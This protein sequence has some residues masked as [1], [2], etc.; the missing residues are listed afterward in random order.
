MLVGVIKLEIKEQIKKEMEN[1]CNNIKKLRAKHKLT[2]KGMAKIL[3][4]GVGSLTKIE[5]G[6]MPK[7]LRADIFFYI[8]EKFNIT[9]SRIVMPLDMEQL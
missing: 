4:I 7:L 6:T 3:H 1:F 2:K 8:H 5:N 9:A